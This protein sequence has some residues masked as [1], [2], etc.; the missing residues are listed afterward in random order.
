MIITRNKI[1]VKIKTNELNIQED[2]TAKNGLYDSGHTHRSTAWGGGGG[3]Q[4]GIGG[5]SMADATIYTS[6]ANL[7]SNDI[8]TRPNNYTFKLWK[9][10]D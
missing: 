9:R 7:V 3:I 6:Y 5:Y 4:Y 8:E 2:T 1:Y 10:I